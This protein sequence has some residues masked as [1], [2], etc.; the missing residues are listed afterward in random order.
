VYLLVHA[1]LFLGVLYTPTVPRAQRLLT[2]VSLVTIVLA[3]MV[4]GS[5]TPI[6]GA[7]VCG[8]ALLVAT[9][10]IGGVGKWAVAINAFLAMAYSFFG[11]GVRERMDSIGSWEHVQRFHDTYFGQLF[12]TTF[13]EAPMGHGLGIATMGARHFTDFNK[14]IF[15]E[16]YLGI[17]AIEMGVFGLIAFLWISV[18]IGIF[19]S[20][21]WRRM[22]ASPLRGIWYS[23]ALLLVWVML[24]SPVGTSLDAAPTNLYFWF[25]IG[26]AARIYDLE[27]TRLARVQAQAVQAPPQALPFEGL[28]GVAGGHAW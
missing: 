18:T 1:V 19:L 14:M 2:I 27:Q 5:R 21:R 10:R 16:S 12:V 8:G 25:F 11:E 28:A 20:T 22:R 23:A 7:L 4:C 17:I 13:N 24:G 26:L 3:L 15:T 6:L 9:G